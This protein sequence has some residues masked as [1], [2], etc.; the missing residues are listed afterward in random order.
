MKPSI[1]VVMLDFLVCSLLLFVI[2]TGGQQTQFATAAAPAVHA[3]FSTAAIQAQQDEWNRDYDQQTLLAQLQSE[4]AAKEQLQTRLAA[5]EENL[6]VLAAEKARVEADK[7][8]T[9]GALRGVE[10][11]LSQVRTER[12]QLQ[13]EG[14]A[15]KER[16]AKLQTEQTRLEAEKGELRQ[17][18][19]Q[20]G[21]TVASQ[22]TTISTLAGEVRASQTRVETQLTDVA[23]GQAA[24]G[25]T[26]AK[27]DEFTRTLPAT[28]QRDVAAMHDDQRALFE[29]VA[30]LAEN[31]KDL[32]TSLNTDDRALLLQAV[33]DVG[34]GQRDLQARLDELIKAG[35][36]DK[37]GESLNTIQAGQEELRQQ[38]VKLSGQ[39][40]SIKSRGP[41]PF[42]A[43]RAARLELRTVI[44]ARDAFD[45]KTARYKGTAYPLVVSAGGRT[46]VVAHRQSWGLAWWGLGSGQEV[47]NVQH[48]AAR[49]NETRPLTGTA[50]AVAAEPRVVTAE[51]SQPL[52]GL[53]AMALAGSASVLQTDQRKFHVFKSTAAGLSFE[54]ET[55]PDLADPRFLI[56]K[57]PLRSVASWFEN[58]A[59]RAD[60]GDYVVTGDG[61]LV[62][63]MLN[64]ER[65]LVLTEALLA[66]CAVTIPLTETASFLRAA[67]QLSRLK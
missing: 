26:L 64:R 20:L 11:Q 24:M 66:E 53:T 48:L 41:G 31:V 8:Q 67:Q 36:G 38:T 18:A 43:V 39:I 54:A 30:S 12:E 9:E 23:R 45:N 59:Y 58:P 55:A 2:G 10:Q 50:C 27:L 49:E 29:N 61:K 25:S 65:C 33:T 51:L 4:T 21:Q 1:L 60:A 15:A 40:E 35:Q 22:Q 14:E 37:F 42:G 19:E 17:R 32:Q 62:G 47:L 28:L 5:R 46:L 16:L 3:E 44:N 34:L 52:P 63:L 56:V 57:R 6:Q 7:A 13:Q